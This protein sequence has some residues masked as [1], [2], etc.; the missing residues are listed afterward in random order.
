MPHEIGRRNFLKLSSYAYA[1]FQF[2]A[3]RP[4]LPAADQEHPEGVGRVTVDEIFV[5]EEPNFQSRRIRRRLRDELIDL[6]E[7]LESPHGPVYNRT[8]YRVSGGYAHSAYLQRVE[9][10]HLNQVN[11]H[12]ATGGQLAELTV[13]FFHALRPI[14]RTQRWERLYRLYYQTTHWVTGLVDGPDASPW[15]QI[16]NERLRV[17]YYVPASHMRIISPSEIIPLSPDVPENEK[18]IVV[19]LASQTVTAYEGNH[20]VFCA[21]VST[22][23][24][25]TR[26]PENGI[27]TE[28]PPGR[29]NVARKMPSRHMGDGHIT[30]DY[31]AYELLGVP[32]AIFFVSTG[33]AFHGTYWHDNFGT[34]MSRGCVNMRNDDAKWLF[35]WSTPSCQPEDWYVQGRGTVIDV[36]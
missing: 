20:P 32:W 6:F 9:N 31:R 15:Y 12:I 36:I 33:V 21:P 4:L 27:P 19:D 13:P 16:T 34:R 25:S 17:K 14:P 22:G 26:P 29:F 8:W 30:S 10:A 3:F 5:Y 18:R 2:R 11:H 7:A 28:T 24:R 23:I 35:R 1:G